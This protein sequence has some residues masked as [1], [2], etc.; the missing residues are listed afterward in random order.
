[1]ILC[2]FEAVNVNGHFSRTKAFNNIQALIK[3]QKQEQNKLYNPHRNIS[4]DQCVGDST[5][6]VSEWFNLSD[7]REWD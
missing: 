6:P 1:M 7:W 2:C 4:L 5:T 3:K